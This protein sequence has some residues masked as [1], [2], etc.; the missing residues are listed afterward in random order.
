MFRT[1]LMFSLLMGWQVPSLAQT[2]EI[3]GMPS[4]PTATEPQPPPRIEDDPPAAQQPAPQTDDSAAADDSADGVPRPPVLPAQM[5]SG[6]PIE[7][8]VTIIKRDGATIEEY[9][10]N[11]KMYMVKITPSAGKPYYLV[12][13]D[14]DGQMESRMSEVYDDFVVPQWVIFSW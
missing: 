9:R 2:E 10:V 7:P 3:P 6:A 11:G 14:G 1:A 12:D 8:E 4:D 13:R 5:E